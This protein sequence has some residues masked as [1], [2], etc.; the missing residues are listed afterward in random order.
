[1]KKIIILVFSFF[2]GVVFAQNQRFIYD[3]TF[4]SDSTAKDQSKTEMMYLD[5]VSKGSE[6]YSRDKFITDSLVF[7]RSKSSTPDY[8]GIK[9]GAI[10]YIVEKSYPDYTIRFINRIYGDDYKV[11]DNRKLNWK[12]SPEKEKIGEFNVQK[13]SLDFGGRKWIAWFAADIPIQD[14]PYKFHGL[15]GLIVKISDE[16]HS[17]IFELKG[18][19]KTKENIGWISDRNKKMARNS[20]SVG[21]DQYKK[22]FVDSRN[23]PTKD[24]RQMLA[25]NKKAKLIG[26]NGKEVD[27]NEEL[28]KRDRDAKEEY[29]RDNNL[30]EL[31]L[32]K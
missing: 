29:A 32:L 10:P 17:H 8:R 3:Y 1:M 14:G 4:V 30:L 2:T 12:I 6:F 13:A 16:T 28:R 7:E 31:D 19:N 9:Y 15:P 26:E 11:A 24:I 22:V 27:A 25:A 5:V 18:I 23:N 21:T 20:L